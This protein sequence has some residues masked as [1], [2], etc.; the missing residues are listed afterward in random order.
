MAEAGNLRERVKEPPSPL[1]V[2]SY[3]RGAVARAQA[4][5]FDHEMW[6]HLAHGLM[7]ERQGVVARPAIAACLAEVLAMAEAGPESVPVDHRQEDLYSYVERRIIAALGPDVGGRLHTGRSRNDLNATTWRM[8]LRSALIEVQRGVLALRATLLRLAEQH[9]GTV[10]PGYTHGQH[11]QPITFGY[12]LLAAADVLARDQKRLAGAFAHADLCPLGAGALATTAFPLDR[13]YTA[14]LLG[15]AAPLD[16]AYDA[17]SSRDDALEAAAAMALLMTFL[18]RLATDLMAWGSWEY[19]FLELADRHSAVSS[20]M[21]QKK[22]P[23]ALEHAKAAAAMVTGSLGAALAMTKNTGFADV[24]DAVTA[25]NEPVLD[26]AARTRRILAL[27]EE[28]FAG[29]TL[30][31]ARMAQAAAEGFGTATELADVIVRESGLSFRQAHGIVATVVRQALEQGRA[32]GSIT[33]AELDA[34]AEAAGIAPPRLAPALVAAALDPAGNIAGRRVPGGPAPEA[35]APA[36]AARRT[37]WA[38]E[39]AT[40]QA[41]EGRL[42]AARQSCFAAARALVG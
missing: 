40:L 27:L 18:S 3:Y 30:R 20:I 32:A 28:V 21:P 1:L 8:A 19:G 26:A 42:A 11:A 16:S 4:L 10:M 23:V 5:V 39:S 15:F 2:E 35:M 14:A 24:N 6:A 33:G 22:N 12:W 41:V 31:P 13:A 9:A 34:A 25:V 7:L 38:A 37:A 29:L 36:L 17:V